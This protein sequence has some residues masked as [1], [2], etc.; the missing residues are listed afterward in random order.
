[1]FWVNW[2]QN[3]GHIGICGP[4]AFEN[5]PFDNLKCLDHKSG[6]QMQTVTYIG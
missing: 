2:Y 1:M 3:D 5:G 6:I 4:K